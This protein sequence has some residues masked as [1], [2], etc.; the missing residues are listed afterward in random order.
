ML[1]K[2]TLMAGASAIAIFAAQ[3]VMSGE[4]QAWGGDPN[5]PFETLSKGS[6]VPS[7]Q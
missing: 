5:S 6:A 4:A 1:N 7:L 3:S 2:K